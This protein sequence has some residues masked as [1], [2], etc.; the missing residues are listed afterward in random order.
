MEE[1]LTGFIEQIALTEETARKAEDISIDARLQLQE[2]I[3]KLT[4][5]IEKTER[6][7]WKEVQPKKK[8]A[9]FQKRKGY[10]QELED[11]QR[12]ED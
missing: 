5:L 8:F 3:G 11:L 12:G 9:F 1:I 4:K 2:K 6:A 10:K 7:A